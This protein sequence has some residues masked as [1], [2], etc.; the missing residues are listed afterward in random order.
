MSTQAQDI[1]ALVELELKKVRDPRVIAHIRQLLV[2]PT[3]MMRPWDYGTPGQMFPCWSVLDHPSSNTGIVYC[4]SG[5]GPL[6]PWGLVNLNGKPES[7]SM[8]MDSGWFRSFV[9]AYFDSMASTD[10]PIYHV[11]KEG[12]AG[13]PGICLTPELDWDSAWKEVYRLRE[14][15]LDGRYYC[16]HNSDLYDRS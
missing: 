2:T 12:G 15:D 9:E 11:Y 6:S 1:Q 14:L 10:L 16:S 4:L 7:L 13:D 3:V 8:G 5:F